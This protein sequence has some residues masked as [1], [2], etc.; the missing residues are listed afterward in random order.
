[1]NLCGGG[2]GGG[3]VNTPPVFRTTCATLVSQVVIYLK[4]RRE[5]LLEWRRHTIVFC[6]A[7]VAIL[8]TQ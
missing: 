5:L 2:E 1:M 6:L 7:W 3:A 8:I 4:Q